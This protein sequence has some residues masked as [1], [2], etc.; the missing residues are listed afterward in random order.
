MSALRSLRKLNRRG[1]RKIRVRKKVGG[2]A[3][4]PRLSVFRSAKHI[5]AQV[6]DDEAGVTLAAASSMQK[7][8]DAAGKKIDVAKQVG[9]ALAEVCK[10][11][12]IS[13][14]V[15]DRSGFRYHG[16]VRAVAEGAREGGLDF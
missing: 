4:R 12:E 16:R 8:L 3:L 11:K 7:S 13:Q 1:R 2:T 5:Y 6:V 15:F 14:V 9:L 10:G